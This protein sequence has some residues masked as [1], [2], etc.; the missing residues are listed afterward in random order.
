MRRAAL[1]PSALTLPPIAEMPALHLVE[2]KGRQ[3]VVRRGIF[4]TLIGRW[5]RSCYQQIDGETILADECK[6][7]I[8]WL[9]DFTVRRSLN[10]PIDEHSVAARQKAME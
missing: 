10:C 5:R 8:D 3:T 4:F 6:C 7:W 9:P 2:V 1:S